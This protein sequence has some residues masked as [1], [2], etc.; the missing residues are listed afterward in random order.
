MQPLNGIQFYLEILDKDKIKNDLIDRFAINVSVSSLERANYTGIFNV[1]MLEVSFYLFNSSDNKQT[2]VNNG[3]ELLVTIYSYQ[4]PSHRCVHC[5]SCC[6]F[7]SCNRNGA[8]CDTYFYMCIRPFEATFT[9]SDAI[10]QGDCPPDGVVTTE[11]EEDI[12]GAKFD[13]SV[14][15]V[16]NPIIFS[17]IPNV[18]IIKLNLIKGN[19]QNKAYY[20]ACKL[21]QGVELQNNYLAS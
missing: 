11:Y 19:P 5:S 16:T 7:L 17:K 10:K 1:A 4:N 21:L 9:R 14:F 6:D 15:G 20:I 18:S 8:F 12:D 3:Y 2:D 13:D